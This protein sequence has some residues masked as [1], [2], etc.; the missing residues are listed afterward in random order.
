MT[1]FQ[2]ERDR[3]AQFHV[4]AAI[5]LAW[6]VRAVRTERFSVFDYQLLRFGVHVASIEV[7][8]RYVPRHRYATIILSHTKATWLHRA[9]PPALLVVAW[10]DWTGWF[11][12]SEFHLVGR[13]GGREERPGSVHDVELIVDIPTN[14]FRPLEDWPACLDLSTVP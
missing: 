2:T 10:D 8:R 12:A 7:K 11:P 3:K 4:A 5:E 1:T 9:K 14:A 13:L 6:N